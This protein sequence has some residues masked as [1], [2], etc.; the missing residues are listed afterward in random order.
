MSNSPSTAQYALA[1]T[2]PAVNAKVLGELTD[3][4][5]RD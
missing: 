5:L 1:L 2:L 3:T 4:L